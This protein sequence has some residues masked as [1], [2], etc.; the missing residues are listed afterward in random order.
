MFRF[1]IT[2]TVGVVVGFVLAKLRESVADQSRLREARDEAIRYRA[3]MSA[4]RQSAAT[5][6]AV[7]TPAAEPAPA[8]APPVQNDDLTR[9][10][11]I[12]PV[13]QS[14]LRAAGLHSYA[15]L[16]ASD[17][18]TVRAAV[19]AA[20]WQKIEPE[21]WIEEAAQLAASE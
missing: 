2:L 7:A 5:E 3:Q 13:F 15:Q 1:L 10:N 21:R 8:P 11:G 6:V 14:R 12:G 19:A 16:A 17:A 18:G 4:A 9:I 20:D